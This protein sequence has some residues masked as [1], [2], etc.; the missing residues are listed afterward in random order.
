MFNLVPMLLQAVQA[1]VV[2]QAQSLAADHVEKAIEEHLPVEAKEALDKM[3]DEDSTHGA[4]NLKE[5]LN[6]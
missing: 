5:L 4:K 3:I 6:L 1:M 2:D